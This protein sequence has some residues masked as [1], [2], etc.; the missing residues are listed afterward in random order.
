LYDTVPLK[1]KVLSTSAGCWSNADEGGWF[2]ADADEGGWF[3]AEVCGE[4]EV[5]EGG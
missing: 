2:E 4:S 1:E 3:E 5:A